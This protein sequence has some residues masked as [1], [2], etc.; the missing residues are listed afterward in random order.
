MAPPDCWKI[1]WIRC[2][3]VLCSGHFLTQSTRESFLS[4]CR[5]IRGTR[6]NV[7]GLVKVSQV[8][9]KGCATR[10]AGWDTVKRIESVDGLSAANICPEKSD[11][12][13]RRCVAVSMARNESK[14]S[15]TP[16]IQ[17]DDLPSYL[18]AVLSALNLRSLDYS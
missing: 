17:I 9:R 5:K 13:I 18:S 8:G 2:R 10:I 16:V 6:D 4:V 12:P 11:P 7:R 3:P 14:Q 15:V 1:Y